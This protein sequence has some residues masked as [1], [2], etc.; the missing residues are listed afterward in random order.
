MNRTMTW[1]VAILLAGT[2]LYAPAQDDPNR[3]PRSGSLSRDFKNDSRQAGA[4]IRDDARRA[5]D[6]GRDK[7]TNAKRKHAV[8]RCNDGQY[9]YSRRNTCSGHG[10]IRTRVR[11]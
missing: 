9:S 1:M 10:G 7:A 8:A 6:R 3:A 2:P 11:R 5:T 4:E